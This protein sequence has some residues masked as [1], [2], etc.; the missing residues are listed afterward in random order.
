[1]QQLL[2]KPIK[3]GI[4]LFTALTLSSSFAIADFQHVDCVEHQKVLGISTAECQVLEKL[5]TS[6]NGK[7][8]IENKNWDTLSQVD[9]WDG[10]V[11]ENSKVSSLLLYSNNL[12]GTI[13]S[14]LGKLSL[15]KKISF[16]NNTLSGELPKSLGELS[17]LRYL[18]LGN[19][20][21][22]SIIPQTLGSLS[23]LTELYLNNNQFS[24]NI[25]DTLGDLEKLIV[26]KIYG[27]NL[28]ESIPRTLGALSN[29]EVLS[30][31][32]NSLT[33]SI[34]LELGGLKK[35]TYLDLKSNKLSGNIPTELGNLESLTGL[36]LQKNSLI[37]EIPSEL[38]NLS[39]LTDLDLSDNKLSGTI[40][41]SVGNLSILTYLNVGH[42]QLHGELPSELLNLTRMNY[43]NLEKNKFV[44]ADIEAL[45][46]DLLD[47]P[48]F[49]ISPELIPKRVK[50]SV[51]SNPRED[52]LVTVIKVVDEEEIA[53]FELATLKI[54]GTK[55]AGDSLFVK[56]EGRW[57][58][59]DNK[60]VFMPI[61][62][63]NDVPTAI[64]YSIN[65]NDGVEQNPIEISVKQYQKESVD[66]N[67]F[68]NKGN[69]LEN[70]L[71]K[72]SLP[73]NFLE[74]HPGST[75]SEDGQELI[76]DSEGTWRVKSNGN[77]IFKAEE[78]FKGK[79]SNVAYVV[80]RK[81]GEKS[82]VGMI[83]M[84]E[85]MGRERKSSQ[86]HSVAL[87]GWEGLI[88]MILFGGLFGILYLRE[89]ENKKV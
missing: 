46:E 59:E 44:Y 61:D 58:I 7:D 87:F 40:P 23:N 53:F 19:N 85:K 18:D 2:H 29:L 35:L 73:E 20:T 26:L 74:E 1:M 30:L 69:Q 37:G 79:P 16:S 8:W 28:S 82:I 25:P 48:A 24:G 15:L 52:S 17:E 88:L 9:T 42:N 71:V 75:L 47:I 60:I 55:E 64:F 3:I 78:D 84:Q 81:S 32:G 43:L 10:V 76:V 57:S 39:N 13:P 72:L 68:K 62:G 50:N 51:E 49:I 89:F 63:F 56:N 6:T 86:S 5:W 83:Q 33:G 80:F 70:S 22:K 65:N 36:Y 41:S 27:N 31:A 12:V 11:V 45:H 21:L 66:I 38:G 54:V 67:I 77:I 34:P 14:E 4:L